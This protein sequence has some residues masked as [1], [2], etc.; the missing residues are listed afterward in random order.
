M[1]IQTCSILL[2]IAETEYCATVPCTD[3]ATPNMHERFGSVSSRPDSVPTCGKFSLTYWFLF[4][5]RP[6][7]L[8]NHM[9]SSKESAV[10]SG[11]TYCVVLRSE[12]SVSRDAP[13]TPVRPFSS[14]IVYFGPKLSKGGSRDPSPPPP[15]TIHPPHRATFTTANSASLDWFLCMG[16]AHGRVF[17][18]MFSDGFMRDSEEWRPFLT[19]TDCPSWHE[20]A[21]T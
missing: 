8:S 1:Q 15:F 10:R 2:P 3:T 18:F 16:K 19:V 20:W 21:R 13:V 9:L 11:E 4:T 12:R 7:K 14:F 5:R 6:L 17:K